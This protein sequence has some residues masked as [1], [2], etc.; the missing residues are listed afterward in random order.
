MESRLDLDA[1]LLK[2]QVKARLLGWPEEPVQLGRFAIERCLGRGG[3]GAVYAARDGSTGTR[4]ALKRLH[5]GAWAAPALRR[6]FRS[7][8]RIVHPNLVALHE[9]FC[10]QDQW[11]LTMEL[12]EGVDL[13]AHVRAHGPAIRNSASE[14][15]LRDSFAQ[16]L[17]GVAAIHDAG[18]IHRD[19]KPSN[20]LVAEG[21]R[22]VILDYGLVVDQGAAPDD[23]SSSGT[24]SYMAPEQLQGGRATPAADLY[25]VGTM[26]FLALTGR[27]P[28]RAGDTSMTGTAPALRGGASFAPA[29]ALLHPS[30]WAASIA[31][32]LD[33]LCAELLAHDPQRRPSAQYAR[34]RVLGERER[35]SGVHEA[36]VPAVQEP[37]VGRHAQLGSLAA[38][39][40]GL[41]EGPCVAWLHGASGMGKSALLRRFGAE[42]RAAG[43]LVLEGR[44]YERENTPFKVFDGVID[45]LVR[46]LEQLSSDELEALL[47]SR[48]GSLLYLFPAF[49]RLA[50]LASDRPS[51]PRLGDPLEQQ[52]IA[53]AALRG[54]LQRVCAQR[55]VVIAVDDLQ[56]GDVDSVRLLSSLLP[57]PAAPRL[58]FV[59]AFRSEETETSPFLRRALAPEVMHALGCRVLDI[60]LPGLDADEVEALV[61]QVALNPPG[62]LD[63]AELAPSIRAAQGMPFLLCEL[64]QHGTRAAQGRSDGP[65]APG[66]IEDFVSSRAYRCS[67]A[68]RRLL[69][70]LCI[71]GRPLGLSLAL[72]AAALDDSAWPAASELCSLRL[73]RWRDTD[74]ERCIEP[75]HDYVRL[76]VSV[77]S[78]VAGTRS[79]QAAIAAA[80]QR[81]RIDE[82]EHLALHLIAAGE[83]SR[84]GGLA[85]TAAERA[86]L[87]TAWHRASEL[88]RTALALLDPDTAREQDLPERLARALEH[89]AEH[90]DAADAYL[91]SAAHAL[92]A[93]A[94]RLRRMAAQQLML[95]GRTDEGL[96]L[97][98][99]LLRA[100]GFRYP[101]SAFAGATSF[102]VARAR[103]SLGERL[104]RRRKQDVRKQDARTPAAE[105]RLQTLQVAYRGVMQ[106]DPGVGAVIHAR[107]FLEA[108]GHDDGHALDALIWEVAQRAM[109]YGVSEEPRVAPLVAEVRRLARLLRTPYESALALAA[110]AVYL[111]YCR[112]LPRDALAAND[113][114]FELLS[115]CPGCYFER[116]WIAFSREYVLGVI[117]RLEEQFALCRERERETRGRKDAYS[118]RQLLPMLPLERLYQ[119]QP[120][121]ALQ[122]ID[123]LRLSGSENGSFFGYAAALRRSDVYLYLGD[124]HGAHRAGA[125]HWSRYARLREFQV[126]TLRVNSAFFRGRNAVA[127]YFR[128]RDRALRRE[129]LSCVSYGPEVP[130]FGRGLF[131]MLEACLARAEGRNDDAR[132]GLRASLVEL[133]RAQADHAAMC[134]R[135]RL[136]Q[137]DGDGEQHARVQRWFSDQGV[138]DPEAWVSLTVPGPRGW[139]G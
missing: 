19:L 44:C 35:I 4:V 99:Q 89:A 43:C 116:S 34:A 62:A 77:R 32:D 118:L 132:A 59:G 96:T 72:H 78:S 2:A 80:M 61:R 79:A 10:V 58:L 45:A 63:P 56:W 90:G 30:G 103:I 36:L 86:E 102:F 12:V 107:Y 128:T 9:L 135:Y 1:A 115:E 94:T 27:M 84:A 117:G 26:L 119:G 95:A 73:A 104:P 68:G 54:L 69:E 121:A 60:A 85:I 133:E 129:L 120:D 42:Q 97:F 11:F 21:G 50:P 76:T 16:L 106:L 8:S 25:A 114:A 15:A 100:V 136:A 53:F 47:P 55:A 71:A 127:L 40:G 52:R 3:V 18:K 124:E 82:P 64:L 20:V 46:Q 123:A 101:E 75:Y 22:S 126:P 74:G 112:E 31:E 122:F 83:T 38:A 6:E 137:L 70:V 139:L 48:A 13:I 37:F 23:A 91:A 5:A 113:R 109:I 33:Q 66:R 51:T 17:A 14:G 130:V 93:E 7:L 65:A 24:P 28:Q 98:K 108:R 41:R 81:L 57:R 88:Y 29:E 138:R 125:E 67:Q 134:V 131:R 92:G 49:A 87:A 111:T 39:L 105:E 110:E